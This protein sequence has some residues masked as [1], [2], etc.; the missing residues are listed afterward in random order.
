MNSLLVSNEVLLPL[1]E[2]NV[3]IAEPHEEMTTG[4]Y[5]LATGNLHRLIMPQGAV[6]WALFE[7]WLKGL[8]EQKWV[9]ITLNKLNTTTTLIM[10]TAQFNKKQML[11]TSTFPLCSCL[12]GMT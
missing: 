10:I 6:K 8:T 5:A 9:D 7:G 3:S 1:E 11:L 2:W 12:V 4:F